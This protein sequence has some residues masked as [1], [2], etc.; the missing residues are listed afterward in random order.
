MATD[1]CPSCDRGLRDGECV[2]PDCGW[3]P[4]PTTATAPKPA[5]HRPV[6]QTPPRPPSS[7]QRDTAG[8]WR[9]TPAEK[10]VGKRAVAA[11]KEILAARQPRPES[12]VRAHLRLV[13]NGDGRPKAR[14]VAGEVLA[15]LPDPPEAS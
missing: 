4:G 14:Q 8:V 2:I 6:P 7:P 1:R 5:V 10:A 15:E 12:P 3:Q 13:A 9:P 11:A